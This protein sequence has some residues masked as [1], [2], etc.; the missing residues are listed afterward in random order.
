M[1][2]TN[3][4]T[5]PFYNENAVH[6]ALAALAVVVIALTAFNAYRIVTL[7]RRHTELAARSSRED[8]RAQDLNRQATQTRTRID[9]G[10]LETIAAAAREANTIIDQR[11][12][13]W[14]DLFN[15]IETTLPSD[16]MLTAVRPHIEKGEVTLSL[17]V[18]GRR[19]EDV[20]AFMD[21]LESTGAFRD[22][23]V[24]EDEPTEEGTI[25]ALVSGRY[26]PD[27]SRVPAQ[28]SAVE[29]PPA[30]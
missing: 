3:L 1:I 7:S 29:A 23:L 25:K 20:D 26:L 15:H 12:F 6:A 18:V 2:R 27:P 8:T 19:V 28:E 30:P 10:E 24:V 16:V 5:R 13:P 22:L 21:K 17:A 14:T 11:T 9:T 4:T